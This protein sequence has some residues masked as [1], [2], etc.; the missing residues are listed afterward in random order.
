MSQFLLAQGVDPSL[1]PKS[2]KLISASSDEFLLS[3]AKRIF[4]VDAIADTVTMVSNNQD[5]D[6]VFVRAQREISQGQ[7]YENTTLNVLLVALTKAAKRVALWYGSDV[8]DLDHVYDLDV[9]GRV[10]C[11]GLASPSIEVYALFERA[12]KSRSQNL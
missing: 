9:L 6:A 4:G 3:A 2:V 1:L 12:G 7:S 10:V 11:D 8:A 5:F